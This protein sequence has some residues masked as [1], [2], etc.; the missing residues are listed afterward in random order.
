MEET[1][2]KLENKH[3]GKRVGAGSKLGSKYK[4]TVA[5]EAATMYLIRRIEENIEPLTTALIM[6][7]LEGDMPALKESFE[8]GLGKVKETHRIE[9]EIK[10]D[11]NEIKFI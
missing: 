8:R 11:S 9:G 4:K 2:D 6:K 5:K 10:I 7:A 1:L 3:G